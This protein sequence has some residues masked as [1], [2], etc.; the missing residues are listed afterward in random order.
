MKLLYILSFLSCT[1][2]TTY[3]KIDPIKC[4][5]VIVFTF[6]K[7]LSIGNK[8]FFI[9]LQTVHSPLQFNLINGQIVTDAPLEIQVIFDHTTINEIYLRSF[10]NNTY[11]SHGKWEV[12]AF[13]NMTTHEIVIIVAKSHYYTTFNGID[14]RTSIPRHPEHSY[15]DHVLYTGNDDGTIQNM[16]ISSNQYADVCCNC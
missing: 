11:I 3:V 2:A 4:S 13:Q 7:K 6:E 9:S 10:R 5:T 12:E 1:L 16:I 8:Y 15:I 14:S